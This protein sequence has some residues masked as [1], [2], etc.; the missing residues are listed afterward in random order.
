MLCTAAPSTYAQRG[1]VKSHPETGKGGT[2]PNPDVL[3]P[4]PEPAPNASPQ[5]HAAAQD[6]I[7][8]Y[9]RSPP[10]FAD[11]RS[12]RYDAQFA[13]AL[14]LSG[15]VKVSVAEAY[16][17]R[18]ELAREWRDES[19]NGEL[20]L[21]KATF[22]KLIARED[23]RAENR[24]REELIRRDAE[25][26]QKATQYDEMP[27]DLRTITVA[28]LRAAR[29]GRTAILDP[30]VPG[31]EVRL[32]DDA[33]FDR[34]IIQYAWFR[35]ATGLVN[36][37]NPRKLHIINLFR[38]PTGDQLMELIEAKLAFNRQLLSTEI[39]IDQRTALD[40]LS[41]MVSG[42]RM[43]DGRD[44]VQALGPLK[45]ETV[46]LVS[47]IPDAHPGNGDIEVVQGRKVINTPISQIDAVFKEAQ[48]NL[49]VVGCS[50][51]LHAPIG[52]DRPLNNVT[53]LGNFLATL[54]RNSSSEQLP[55]LALHASFGGK[56]AKLVIDPLHAKLYHEEDK[57]HSTLDRVEIAHDGTVL[58]SGY[59]GFH[60]PP[61]IPSGSALS[62]SI[63]I[64]IAA[65]LLNA[66]DNG[67]SCNENDIR[68]ID[69]ASRL[70]PIA[71]ALLFLIYLIVALI[72]FVEDTPEKY[73]DAV[74]IIFA[75]LILALPLVWSRVLWGACLFNCRFEPGIW[76]PVWCTLYFIILLAGSGK[77]ALSIG[78]N[79]W[80][81][82]AGAK[83]AFLLVSGVIM[84][85]AAVLFL[86]AY[87]GVGA[88]EAL[89]NYCGA[90]LASS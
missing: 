53:A 51:S 71:T 22:E 35:H 45:G 44:L 76:L 31:I 89:K 15:A 59:V 36:G 80:I 1:P 25:L 69:A 87:L 47:H 23:V 43:F 78:S 8:S 66:P 82:G 79:S 13:V 6:K 63:P 64:S 88:A 83:A 14:Y 77:R 24:T 46:Y 2:R 21:D 62:P 90:F 34:E 67:D 30:N 65:K 4:P 7:I 74:G 17:Y 57:T 3:R 52:F 12:L 40:A 85:G 61:P 48:V 26:V 42:I 55:L 49:L 27:R 84:F 5:E 56:Q 29:T 32:A 33:Q 60:A 37:V 10:R 11:R 41:K 18:V 68:S 20:K 73:E 9:L 16:G 86:S 58:S 70:V 54:E 19:R 39:N 50:S 75:T 38:D 81:S 28:A 72:W